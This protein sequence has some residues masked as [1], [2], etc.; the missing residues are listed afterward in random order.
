MSLDRTIAVLAEHPVFAAL[1]PEAL[2][3]LAFS[4]DRIE[5]PPGTRLFLQGEPADSGYVLLAGDLDLEI[6]SGGRTERLGRVPAG[7]LL[8]EMALLCQTDRPATA[9]ARSA[10][11]AIRIPRTVFRRL[12]EE[13][14]AGA[15]ALRQRLGERLL[16]LTGAL[17]QV[18]TRL[19][20]GLPPSAE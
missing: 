3:I 9:V 6:A 5:L 8:G 14:P 13:Y 7:A 20:R 16:T 4:S 1:E 17:D 11:E 18:R 2:R 15:E 12:L 10:I 19:E